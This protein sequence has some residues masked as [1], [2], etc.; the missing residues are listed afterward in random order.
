M[1][2]TRSHKAKAVVSLYDEMI[3]LAK[4]AELVTRKHKGQQEQYDIIVN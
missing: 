3:R 4:E 2:L 1:A